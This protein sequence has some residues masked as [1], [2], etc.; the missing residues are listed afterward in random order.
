MCYYYYYYYQY[1]YIQNVY[2]MNYNYNYY[3][4]LSKNAKKVIQLFYIKILNKPKYINY[5]LLFKNEKT[6]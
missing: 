1:Y 4:F 3:F 2:L 6:G 5:F